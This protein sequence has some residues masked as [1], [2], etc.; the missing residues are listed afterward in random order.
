MKTII[1]FFLFC[2]PLLC[3]AQ[4]KPGARQIALSNSDAAMCADVF[5]VFNN[6][7]GLEKTG[8]KQIGFF[9]SPSP[10]GMKE[11]ANGYLCANQ[12]FSFG[13]VGFGAMTYGYEL[14]KENKY[15]LAF[16]RRLF[17]NFYCGGSINYQTVSIKNYG[18]SGSVFFNAGVLYDAMNQL[19]LGF[20]AENL[21][22]A[23]IGNS[24]DQIPT[25]LNA[26]LSYHPKVELYLNAAIEKDT[27]YPFSLKF[28]VEYTL[29]KMISLR[30]GF[31]TEPE[32]FSAGIGINYLFFN[33]DYSIQ[34]HPDLGISHQ[35]GL[36]IS[37]DE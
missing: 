14:Y 36:L 27:E 17:P 35:F 9:Y 30:T 23:T 15:T 33:F 6:I 12:P 7:A 16:S 22:H 29:I 13:S 31:A 28:G 19:S 32:T 8:G 24:K 3:I 5:T 2:A 21:T 11:M 34:N 10:Y 18:N 4:L 25:I 1:C 37:I 20:Y 26:G